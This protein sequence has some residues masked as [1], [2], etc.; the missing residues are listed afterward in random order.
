MQELADGRRVWWRRRGPE[1]RGEREVGERT[2][3]R[4]DDGV[5]A[6]AAQAAG[7][8]GTGFAHP[9]APNPDEREHSGDEQGADRVDVPDRI[10]RRRPAR[11]AVSSPKARA[12]TPCEISWRM[13]E[14][15]STQ[16]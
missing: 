15:T 8:T 1:R 7:L 16:K 13:I 2:G 10:E 4:H 9:Y 12:T 6:G 5:V 3:E 14:G 11:L